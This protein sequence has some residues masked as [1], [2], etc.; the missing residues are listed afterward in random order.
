MTIS[1]FNFTK[2]P[3]VVLQTLKNR[4]FPERFLGIIKKYVILIA[5]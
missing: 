3:A 5:P 1:K 4:I 2:M